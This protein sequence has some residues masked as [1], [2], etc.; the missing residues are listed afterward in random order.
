MEATRWPQA[1]SRSRNRVRK[2]GS[3]EY[4]DSRDSS[5]EK[6]PF[7]MTPFSSPDERAQTIEYC[8]HFRK[9]AKSA[10]RSGC[11]LLLVSWLVSKLSSQDSRKFSDLCVWHD[12][13]DKLAKRSPNL[14]LVNEVFGYSAEPSTLLG[15][16]GPLEEA[17]IL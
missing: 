11:L 10:K 3:F 9:R 6:T 1:K 8:K 5:S 12:S 2:K 7:V 17:I 16:A 15:W 13:Q 14:G 4:R